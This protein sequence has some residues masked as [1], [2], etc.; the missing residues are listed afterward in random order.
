[1]TDAA[2]NLM[3]DPKAD[4]D[5]RVLDLGGIS[6]VW[7][8]KPGNTS[9][10]ELNVTD[11]RT[12]GRPGEYTVRCA[13][14]IQ[15]GG[16]NLEVLDEEA[17][18][19]VETTFRLTVLPA[20]EKNV[21]RALQEYIKRARQGKGDALTRA[22]TVA[23]SF[24]GERAVPDLA[25]MATAGDAEHRIAA[26]AGL[27]RFTTT[28][29]VQAAL[30]GQRDSDV[31]V[32][33]AAAEALGSQKTEAAVNGLLE[34]LP[35]ESPKVAVA[36]LPALGRT[37]SR[38]A[39]APLVK[40][41][42]HANVEVRQAAAVGLGEL[43]GEQALATLKRCATD[44][45]L[46]RREAVVNA[47]T[48][49]FRQPVQPEW[50]LP[51]IRAGKRYPSGG[52]NPQWP[53]QLL[54]SYGDGNAPPALI[55]CVD[56]KD[57]APDA[58][59]NVWIL[60]SLHE[61]Y[62]AKLPGAPQKV[63]WHQHE[64]NPEQV[65]ENWHTLR[66]LK[67]WLVAQSKAEEGPPAPLRPVPSFPPKV[68]P[69]VA[70]LI[71]QLSSKKFAEREAAGKALLSHGDE[72]MDALLWAA[73]RADL[74]TRRRAILLMEGIEQEWERRRLDGH[75]DVVLDVA[76]SPDGKRAVWCNK[77]GDLHVRD[78]LGGED[79]RRFAPAVTA[80]AVSPDGNHLLS[81]RAGEI[82]LE[83]LATG[84]GISTL[85]G[86]T[87]SVACVA[88][89]SDGKRALS[90]G[91]DATV[92]LWDIAAGKEL[93][94]FR[95][96]TDGVCSVAVAKDGRRLLSASHDG[97]VRLWDSDSGK[98]LRCLRGHRDVVWSAVLLPDGKR[99]L[100]ASCDRT[101][102]LWDL[103]SGRELRRF[104]GHTDS[105]YSVALADDGRRFVSGSHDG[106]ARLWDLD[107]GRELQRLRLP[108]GWVEKV[109]VAPDSRRALVGG[110]AG[111][112]RLWELQK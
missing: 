33:I 56:F 65:R 18:F 6:S 69:V 50:L 59:T 29:A 42:D 41:L 100:S 55:R 91:D 34:R 3:R 95:G 70:R 88:F 45:D 60:Q 111:F 92:R 24:G 68:G 78:V 107:S 26:L 106:T 20:T 109:A 108:R 103:E 39:L 11:Y 81:A 67:Y 12:I 62:L 105:I 51:L 7:P 37:Q 14:G 35:G 36:L 82:T 94:R 104:L 8:V 77:A 110:S 9:K 80:L 52:I 48:H 53:I 49:K 93:R 44:E 19:T 101:V 21:R 57:P 40:A 72:A 85:K 79:K 2:G 54:R 25:A 47:L 17:A 112:L 46:E 23:C 98:E 84:R 27:A 64:L 96:H 87:G 38:R 97:T 73:N 43:Q 1:V 13:F 5:G 31:R 58:Y 76:F 16:P 71:E 90:G 75:K 66:Q 99:V 86:H 22:V 63:V 15:R 30:K 4:K 102:R 89:S 83:E 10:H 74:E 61:S 32:R 28:A